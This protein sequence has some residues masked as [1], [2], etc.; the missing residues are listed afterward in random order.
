M[1]EKE[2]IWAR[3]IE[4]RKN[5]FK[6]VGLIGLDL[7]LLLLLGRATLKYVECRVSE[8]IGIVG[9]VC[10]SPYAELAMD[11]DKPHQLELMRQHLGNRRTPA[12]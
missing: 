5:V 9:R 8:R 3:L 7:L 1:L 11:I 6:Q 2:Y 4:A 12:T 10:L